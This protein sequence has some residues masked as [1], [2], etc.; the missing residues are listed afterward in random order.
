MR[1]PQS[2]NG[3]AKAKPKI[4]NPKEKNLIKDNALRLRLKPHHQ[5]HR[6]NTAM[7]PL[8]ETRATKLGSA[9]EIRDRRSVRSDQI[10]ACN[11]D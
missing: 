3:K 5:A 10:R 11:A 4:R 7:A 1:P 9:S 2:S 8:P 6:H